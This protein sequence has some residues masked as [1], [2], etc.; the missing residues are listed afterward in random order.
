MQAAGIN[1]YTHPPASPRLCELARLPGLHRGQPAFTRTG[2]PPTNEV[3]F[4]AINRVAGEGMTEVKL[5]SSS[6]RP[7]SVALLLWL[8]ARTEMSLGPRRP[9]RLDPSGDLRDR[10]TGHPEPLLIALT[11]AALLAW[12][13]RASLTAGAAHG[14]GRPHQVRSAPPGRRSCLADSARALPPPWRRPPGS[15]RSRISVPA[16]PRSGRSAPSGASGSGRARTAGLWT[17]GCRPPGPGAPAWPRWAGGRHDGRAT[18]QESRGRLPLLR[19]APRRGDAGQQQRPAL[20]PALDPAPAVRG[21]GARPPVGDRHRIGVLPGD[22]APPARGPGRHLRDRLGPDVAL[23]AVD[24]L[25][26]ADPSARGPAH[27][28]VVPSG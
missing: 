22:R 6:S 11:L 28:V 5:A 8:L 12:D 18:A 13:R 17:R 10:R 20:V 4:Y 24:V 21:T 16:Q 15:W 2:Y 1:P 9:L 7:P 27:P 25:R 14:R 19:P 3:A 23:L 26:A